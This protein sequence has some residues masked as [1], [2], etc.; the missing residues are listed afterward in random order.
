MS[1]SRGLYRT[2]HAPFCKIKDAIERK[3]DLQSQTT[4]VQSYKTRVKVKDT[5][6]GKLLQ[7]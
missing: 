4:E 1:N 5:D 6:N 7:D 2:T 3:I